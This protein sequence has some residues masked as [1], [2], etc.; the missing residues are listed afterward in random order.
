MLFRS[1]T[2]I[3]DTAG[4]LRF[5]GTPVTDADSPLTKVITLRF[6]VADGAIVGDAA[7]G[8][9]VGGTAT[10]RTFTGSIA[11]LNAYLTTTPANITYTPVTNSNVSRT[12]T[13]TASE[14]YGNQTQSSSQTA[15]IVIT[16]VNDAP[17]VTA[18]VS[19]TVTEDVAGN[20]VWP[21]GSAPFADVD[22]PL[23]TVKIGRAH[24]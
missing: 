3:E 14:T 20:L 15:T 22:S 8:V 5:S 11:T 6:S 9:V 17:V 10:A 24:V 13:V 2:V 7:N 21:T 23:L 18:P 19:F 16:P 4:P 12:L 1:F